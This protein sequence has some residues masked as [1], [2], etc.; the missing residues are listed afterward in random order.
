[1]IDLDT[2]LN[3]PCLKQI[4]IVCSLVIPAVYGFT[5]RTQVKAAKEIIKEKKE[6]IKRLQALVDK[7]TDQLINKDNV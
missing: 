1:M 6:E 4:L 2:V 3:G 5:C 7:R